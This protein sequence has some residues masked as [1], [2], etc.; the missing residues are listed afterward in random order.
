MSHQRTLGRSLGRS[1]RLRPTGPDD[2]IDVHN[3]AAGGLA[4]GMKSGARWVGS[5]QVV[6]QVIRV[7]MALVLTYLLDPDEFGLVALITV[8][9]VF[10]ERVLGDTGTT[11]AVVRNP[12][13]THGLVSS[14]FWLNVSIGLITSGAFVAFGGVLAD[15]LGEP[16]AGNLIR[17]A[18]LMAFLNAFG[19]VQRA[20]LRRFLLFKALATVNLSNALMTTTATV[21]FAVADWGAWAL[22]LGNLTGTVGSVALAW[23]WSPWRPGRTFDRVRLREISRFSVNLSI[24]NLFGYVSYAGD[25]FLIG[26]FIGTTELG[27]YGLANRLLR[28][29]LQ[30]TTQT[31]REVVLPG[32]A[33]IQDDHPN[34]RKAYG[35]TVNGIAFLLLPLCL[36]LAALARPLV[37]AALPD[38][39]I[40][41]TN[42]I[43]IMALVGA[44]QSL[45]T[46]TGSIYIAKGRTDLSLKWQMG[47]SAVLMMAYS[48]G[49]LWSTEGVAWGYLVGI[50]VLFYP[51]F[52]IPLGLIDGRPREVLAPIAPTLI[53]SA[54]GA[55]GA[56]IT[57]WSL[58]EAGTGPWVQLV[59]G[60]AV[61]LAVYGSY[62]L[63]GKPQAMRDLKAAISGG[64]RGS[65]NAAA[66]ID[67]D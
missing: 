11:A 15:L 42:I 16:D 34:M 35:R 51:A 43:A 36:G 6:S 59:A 21:S 8:I 45:A 54:V 48:I 32:L 62:V 49:A 66:D 25:R 31:Y 53:A 64:R 29:P 1:A 18:G 56:W 65:R 9:T 23:W 10:F 17:A 20:L 38:K 52:R 22:V 63:I 50:A 37:S 41:A 27:Y 55:S 13:L 58:D 4:K 19:H 30:T 57:A 28:Y 24:Q 5:A 33:R 14:V 61:M 3:S 60:G 44:L 47:S 46:T 2:L 7:V 67:A 12:E 26:R 39:W 40:P